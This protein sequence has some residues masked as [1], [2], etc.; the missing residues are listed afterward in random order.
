MGT[1]TVVGMATSKGWT[2][3][4]RKD[5]DQGDYKEPADDEVTEQVEMMWQ[6]NEDTFVDEWKEL[7]DPQM[8]DQNI[9]RF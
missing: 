8:E 5:Q 7:P 2:S 3:K 6:T 9:E 4:G 1:P